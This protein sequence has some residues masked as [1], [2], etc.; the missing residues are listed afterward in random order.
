MGEPKAQQEWQQT[1][2][3]LHGQRLF[4]RC[5]ALC[6]ALNEYGGGQRNHDSADQQ[7]GEMPCGALHAETLGSAQASTLAEFR[8]SGHEG[9]RQTACQNGGGEGKKTEYQHEGVEFVR[10]AQFGGYDGVFGEGDDLSHHGEHGHQQ[11]ARDHGRSRP[12]GDQGTQRGR[13]GDTDC[14]HSY[15][16]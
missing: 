4:L 2:Q 11:E 13:Q 8:I 6:R 12:P 3:E 1:V 15:K 10:R 16:L 9:L 14:R 5:E 7:R